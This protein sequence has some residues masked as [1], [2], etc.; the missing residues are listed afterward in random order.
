MSFL[1]ASVVKLTFYATAA[2]CLPSSL[3]DVD[4]CGLE[5]D[6]CS[7]YENTRCH[8]VPGGFV[9]DCKPKYHKARSG[10]G[11]C[12]KGKRCLITT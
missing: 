5:R 4:E 1:F 12:E 6:D 3:A 7:S 11:D 10:L 9:C 8:N 2:I